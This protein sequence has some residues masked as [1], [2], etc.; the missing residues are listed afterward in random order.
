MEGRTER[1]IWQRKKTDIPAEN[2]EPYRF[3]DRLPDLVIGSTEQGRI[4][5]CTTGERIKTMCHAGFEGMLAG[6]RI[7]TS[8]IERK[9]E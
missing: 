2:A 8:F 6:K 5:S 3:P 1:D 9:D 7:S 4:I